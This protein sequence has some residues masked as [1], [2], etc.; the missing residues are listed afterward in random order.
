[1]FSFKVVYPKFPEGVAEIWRLSRAQR[2]KKLGC[3]VKLK[4][5][6]DSFPILDDILY[7]GCYYMGSGSLST[8]IVG[9]TAC[10]Q[11][12]ALFLFHAAAHLSGMNV[13]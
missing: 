1:M 7:K 2:C 9:K 11:M 12:T 3:C 8:N 5:E 13:W 6:C 4:T 10:L